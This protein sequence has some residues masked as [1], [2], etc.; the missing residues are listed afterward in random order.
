MKNQTCEY[1]TVPY[2]YNFYNNWRALGMH[3]RVIIIFTNQSDEGRQA[4]R[5]VLYCLFQSISNNIRSL[6]VYDRSNIGMYR[7]ISMS[8]IWMR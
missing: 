1:S 5:Q 2:L 8:C 6:R 3:W 7:V 4:G